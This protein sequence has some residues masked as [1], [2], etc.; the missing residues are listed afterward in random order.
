MGTDAFAASWA[1]SVS[2]F[3]GP[4]EASVWLWLV[5][6]GATALNCSA[7]TTF[8]DWQPIASRQN[9]DLLRWAEDKGAADPR[10]LRGTPRALRICCCKFQ[11]LR[12]CSICSRRAKWPFSSRCYCRDFGLSSRDTSFRDRLRAKADSV[13][14]LHL[15]A[16][17][18]DSSPVDSCQLHCSEPRRAL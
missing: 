2:L 3:S 11:S 17:A 10:N 7:G 14:C 15:L 9:T 12:R 1:P 5:S 4:G 13:A 6:V 16:Q 18:S 8:V